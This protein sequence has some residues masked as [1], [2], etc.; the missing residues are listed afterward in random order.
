MKRTLLVFIFLGICYATGFILSQ[1]RSLNV[2]AAKAPLASELDHG[3]QATLYPLDY[4]PFVLVS[5]GRNNGAFVEKTLR[6]MFSQ[7]YPNYRMIYVDDGSTDGSVS[8]VKELV[9]LSGCK[10][11][12]TLICHK[13]PRGELKNLCE[14]LKECGDQEIVVWIG[15]SDWLAHEWVLSRLNG[16]YADPDLWMTY[17]QYREFPGYRLGQ[18]AS[19]NRLE[20]EQ[21]GFRR[22][23]FGAMHLKTFYAGLFK[24]ISEAD[25]MVQGEF[26]SHAI[27][28]AVMTP[29][30]EMAKDHFQ[31]LS[32]ILYIANKNSRIQ[33]DQES[34]LRAERY[35]RSLA[36]YPMLDHVFNNE[37]VCE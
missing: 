23:A 32:E 2:S 34:Q 13:E 24:K 26:L 25:L 15:G 37:A 18:S 17:G 19:F 3:F 8:L 20:L 14:V 27:D 9:E 11:S 4:H 29:L 10:E 16:Y 12:V 7:V 1:P 28:A 35:I 33:D 21:K 36:S 6:S 22:C 31:C 30:L 5:I